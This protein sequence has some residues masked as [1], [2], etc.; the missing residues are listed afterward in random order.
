MIKIAITQRLVENAEYPERRDCLDVRWGKIFSRLGWLMLPVPS[1]LTDPVQFLKDW[2]VDGAILS[3][4]ND[5]ARFAPSD[6]LSVQRD[7]Q[8][9]RILQF[10]LQERLPVAGICRGMQCMADY[11]GGDL[12][13][14]PG[15]IATR[16]RLSLRTTHPLAEALRN[17][18]DVNSYHRYAVTQAPPDFEVLASGEDCT[19]EAMVHKTL[20]LYGQMWH[21][22]R[23]E[24]PAQLEVLQAVFNVMVKEPRR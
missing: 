1:G 13:M 18:S 3:G 23:D 21:P 4:G 22:E 9:H 15:H 16:H 2:Q 17:I 11:F 24:D 7:A 10:A 12:G 6:P 19:V 20:P 5:I 14:M 8:E